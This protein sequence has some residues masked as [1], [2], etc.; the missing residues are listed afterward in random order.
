M[1][2]PVKIIHIAKNNLSL[3]TEKNSATRFANTP[4][5]NAP[6]PA[7][8]NTSKLANEPAPR[9]IGVADQTVN[10]L[11]TTPTA[12]DSLVQYPRSIK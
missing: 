5:I 1:T 7:K 8:S 12:I 4:P 11:T 9:V 10:A 2:V 6:G 3:V